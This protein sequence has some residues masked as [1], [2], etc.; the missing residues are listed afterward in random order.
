MNDNNVLK[1]MHG[2]KQC[3]DCKLTYFQRSN[4]L[5]FFLF[6]PVP[7]IMSKLSMSSQA[8]QYRVLDELSRYLA[9][10]ATNG[11]FALTFLASLQDNKQTGAGRG[12]HSA[13]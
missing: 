9:P 13:G 11:T 3:S 4:M 6:L 1:H 7:C 10:W 2:A 5:P 8:Y 12:Q